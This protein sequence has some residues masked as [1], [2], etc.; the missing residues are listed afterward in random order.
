MS[1]FLVSD[2]EDFLLDEPSAEMNDARIETVNVPDALSGERLDR[3]LSELTGMTRSAAVRLVELGCVILSSEG[4]TVTPDKKTRLRVGD[5]ITVMHPAVRDAVAEPENIPLDI[6]YEDADIIVLNKPVGMVVHP[7]PG[8]ERGTLVNALLFHCGDEL[9]GVGGVRRPGIV[10]RIDKDTSGLLVV[11]KNDAAHVGLSEQLKSHTV[12]RVY[13][14][15]CVGNLKEDGGTVDFAV[16]RHPNDRKKMA[17]FPKGTDA[18]GV[19]EAVTHYRV[20]ERYPIG[21]KW[22]QALTWVRCELETGRTHQIRVHMAATGH[23]LLGDPVYGGDGTRFGKNCGALIA[24]QMLHAGELRLI[25]PT[26]GKP[27]HF[28]CDLPE[29]YRAVL[30]RLRKETDRA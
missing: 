19:R 5:T 18:P 10:H 1:D 26:T 12:S 27:M 2:K 23:P 8:N 3:I 4:R 25:H 15:V 14:A 24:G 29:N 16:G 20:L 11:A 9:S 21:A 7:A 6:I 22:G 13:F 30:D 28:V 17:A